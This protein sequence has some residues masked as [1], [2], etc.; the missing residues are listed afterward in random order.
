M[1]A[2]MISLGNLSAI[3]I[4]DIVVHVSLLT[5]KCFFILIVIFYEIF[6]YSYQPFT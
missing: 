2:R 5:Y 4:I 3:T 1:H 6:G